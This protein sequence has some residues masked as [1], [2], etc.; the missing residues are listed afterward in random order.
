MIR[1]I[2]SAG[3]KLTQ[4]IS[5]IYGQIYIHSNMSYEEEK[6]IIE[7]RAT[8][9]N[10]PEQGLLRQKLFMDRSA[11]TFELSNHTFDL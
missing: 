10:Y 6:E 11:D 7:G 8:S 1:F 5:H 4:H 9:N 3:H 2:T